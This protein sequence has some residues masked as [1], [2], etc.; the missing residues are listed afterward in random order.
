MA[1][2]KFDQE[3]SQELFEIQDYIENQLKSP[4]AALKKVR[5]ITKAIRLLENFPDSGNY[6]KN[7]Y[8]NLNPA[9]KEHRHIVIGNYI[10]VYLYLEKEGI[11][12]IQSIYDGRTNYLEKISE[13][14]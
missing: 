6:L 14:R 3:A 12:Y 13:K 11:I 1:S 5:E 7:I 4:R 8:P 9:L 2:I 10:V